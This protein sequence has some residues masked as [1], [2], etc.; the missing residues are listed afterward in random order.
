MRAKGDDADRRSLLSKDWSEEEVHDQYPYQAQETIVGSRHEIDLSASVSFRRR[1]RDHS[2]DHGH[3]SFRK[4]VDC[5]RVG[6]YRG[7]HRRPV[8]IGEAAL[9]RWVPLVLRAAK[10]DHGHRA[11]KEALATCSFTIKFDVYLVCVLLVSVYQHQRPLGIRPQ[12]RVSGY[13]RMSSRI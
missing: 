2:P 12:Q 5:V 11:G 4:F 10:C 3:R 7:P 1:T 8:R 6:V 9:F 13:E